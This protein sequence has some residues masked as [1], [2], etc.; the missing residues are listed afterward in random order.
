MEGWV[1]QPRDEDGHDCFAD[2]R[3]RQQG[4]KRHLCPEMSI[5]LDT[6]STMPR[7]VDGV[8]S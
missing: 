8:T 3:A 5:I 6:C 4:K 7:V 1:S 2:R